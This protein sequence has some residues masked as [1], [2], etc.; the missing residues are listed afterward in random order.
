MRADLELVEAPVADLV[1]VADLRAHL[2]VDTTDHDDLIGEYRDAAVAHLDGHA[3]ILG[4]ALAEQTWVLYLDRFPA[5]AGWRS[6]TIR[7]P[8]PPLIAVESITYLDANGVRQTLAADLYTV[9]DGEKAEIRPAYGQAW[10]TARCAP[11]SVAITFT[12]GWAAPDD[13]DPWPAKLQPV[14]AAIKLMVGDMFENRET[15]G[16][17]AEIPAVDRLLSPL[18]LSRVG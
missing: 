4:R 12:C 7:L 3:G 16:G 5:G 9:L 18:K 6:A 8:L 10:P 2:V 15:G 1:T 11:R 13:G 14:R 17:S